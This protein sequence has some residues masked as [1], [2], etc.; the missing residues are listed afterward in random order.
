VGSNLRHDLRIAYRDFRL[1]LRLAT[2]DLRLDVRDLHT[3]LAPEDIN[4]AEYQK[5]KNIH[6]QVH[7]VNDLA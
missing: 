1:D 2:E 6:Y 5:A 4:F 7:V 3:S